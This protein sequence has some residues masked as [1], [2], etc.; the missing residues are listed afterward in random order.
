MSRESWAMLPMHL[1]AFMHA[2]SMLGVTEEYIDGRWTNWGPEIKQFLFAA[3]LSTPAP[4]CAAFINWC[5]E[6]AAVDKNTTSALEDVRLQAY[7]QSY[8][9]WAENNNKFIPKDDAGP[10]DLFILYYPS[11]ERYAHI[12]FVDEVNEEEGW[13]TTIEGNTNDEAS[14]EGF[15]VASRRRTI[16]SRVKFIRWA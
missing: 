13:F 4:W 16:T 10:G 14:R 12:G 9:D 3:G 15:K 5:A 8:A 6:Q 2:Q 7:V 1:N 11:L